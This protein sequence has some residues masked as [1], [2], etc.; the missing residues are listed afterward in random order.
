MS[1]KPT[2]PFLSALSTSATAMP[3]AT[4]ASFQDF[5]EHSQRGE[6]HPVSADLPSSHLEGIG[7]IVAQFATA[8]W[9]L[10]GT[11]CMLLRIDRK[12]GRIAIGQPDVKNA[13]DRIMTLIEIEEIKIQKPT[14][15][16]ATLVECEL[17]RNRLAHS[18]WVQHPS[19][20]L[21]LQVT[22]GAWKFGPPKEHNVD[23][24]LHP[25]GFA[26]DAAWFDQEATILRTAID[27]IVA[28]GAEIRRAL[29]A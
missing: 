12:Q 24:R 28:F 16:I 21:C 3:A 27:E 4:A 6:E 17:T 14:T 1:T 10:A 20:G 2:P 25:E 9:L 19:A 22:K 5:M 8:E 29:G 23:K 13:F 7:R 15:L 26:V 18:I 11:I